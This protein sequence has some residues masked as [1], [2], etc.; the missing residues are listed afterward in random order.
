MEQRAKLAS[1]CNGTTGNLLMAF[2]ICWL[3]CSRPGLDIGVSVYI[4]HV[5]TL[6]L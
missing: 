5:Y 4:A 3:L 6:T 2:A 1:H